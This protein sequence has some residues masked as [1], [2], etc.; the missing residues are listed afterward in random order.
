[1][2]A[3]YI[4]EEKLLGWLKE[5][6]LSPEEAVKAVDA[7]IKQGVI[8]FCYTSSS[9]EDRGKLVPHYKRLTE[10]DVLP[11]EL[12]EA[13]VKR[14]IEKDRKAEKPRESRIK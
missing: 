9:P 14:L 5:K 1:M 6:G 12:E 4:K 7:A 8:R 13:M 10:E 3:E 11:P 2:K